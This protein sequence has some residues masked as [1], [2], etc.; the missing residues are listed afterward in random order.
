MPAAGLRRIGFAATLAA[1]T[2]MLGAAVHGMTRVDQT[3]ELAAA[4]TTAPPAFVVDAPPGP[5]H[6]HAQAWLRVRDCERLP[7]PHRRV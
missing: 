2:L 5:P 7:R 3:L 4:R 1:G 6:R